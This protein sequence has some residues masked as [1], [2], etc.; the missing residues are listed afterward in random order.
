[1]DGDRTPRLFLESRFVLTYP[2]FSSDGQWMAYSFPISPGPMR[3]MCNPTPAPARSFGSRRAAEL[4]QSGSRTVRNFCIVPVQPDSQQVFSVAIHSLSPFRA[5]T[6]RLLF[7]V[8]PGAYGSS[9]P[10]R[11]WD[12]SADGQRFLFLSSDASPH[13]AVRA[14]HIV[15]NWF[16]ELKRLVPTK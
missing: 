2:E 9:A 10:I 1:M 12:V 15:M 3:S 6:P 8:K 5:D 11:G 14:M 13:K 16:E 4:S 7:E